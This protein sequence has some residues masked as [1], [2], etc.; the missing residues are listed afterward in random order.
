MFFKVFMNMLFYLGIYIENGHIFHYGFHC[1]ASFSKKKYKNVKKKKLLEKYET[2]KIF[3]VFVNNLQ[4]L[5]I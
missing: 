2:E 3:Q 1:P 4:I 5:P